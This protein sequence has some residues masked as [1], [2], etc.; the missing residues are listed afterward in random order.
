M[1]R[2]AITKPG[3][4]NR[5]N[6]PLL[7]AKNNTLS[8]VIFEASSQ[9]E[10]VTQ[11]VA[12]VVFLTSYPPRQCGIATFS[13]DLIKALNEKYGNSFKIS[14]YPLET[15]SDRH[16]YPDGISSSLNTDNA[17]DYIQ[18]VYTINA[19]PNIELVVIQ[20]EFGLF[21]GNEKGFLDFL[22]FLDKPVVITF[23]TVLP[24]PD[25]QM[26]QRVWRLGTRC[27][28]IIVM[29]QK[30]ADVLAHEYRIPESKITVIP[31]GTH[32]VH[33]ED[34]AVLKKKYKLSGKKVL[35]TFGLLGPGKSIET[36]LNALPEVVSKFP[37]TMFLIIGCTHP[38]L[39]QHEGEKYRD[40]LNE[41]VTTLGLA[42]N[43]RFVNEFLPLGDLL[44]Y[45]QLTDIYLFTSKDPNQA[46]SG[47]FSY[48]LSC[49][50][51]IISTPIP[52][53]LEVLKNGAG[54]VFD[55]EDSEQLKNALKELLASEAKR[56][57]MR[58]NGLLSSAASAWQ[59]AAISYGKVFEKVIGKEIRLTYQKP[60]IKL[61]H[62]KKLTT[63]VGIIQFAKINHPDLES[64]YTLDDN[65]RALIAL[66]K[67]YT[68][69]GEAS[70]LEYIKIYFNFVYSCFRHTARFL[71]YV[72]K[73]Y[74]FTEQNDE[75]NLEDACGRA[76][77]AV[78]YFLSIAGRLPEKY[79]PIREKARFLF[80][81]YF[82]G[83]HELESPRAIAFTIKGLYYYT[84]G[85][86]DVCVNAI[87]RKYADRLV[88]LYREVTSDNWQWF[89]GYL[90][91]GNS[92]LPQA[93]LMAYCMTLTSEYRCV[94]QESFDFLLSK[95][96]VNDKISVISNQKWLHRDIKSDG[97]YKGGEQPIDVAYTVLAL[98]FF[99]KVFPNNGYDKKMEQ[100]FNWFMGE[101][102]LGQ[103]MYNPCTCGCYDGLELNN[104]NLN[105][106]AESTV[107]YLLARMAFEE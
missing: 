44:E 25:N 78:G 21:S 92:V 9:A 71:N 5:L 96:F 107:S 48:A 24:N 52:H 45:L 65:A 12:E 32:L 75:V 89:E 46:V 7:L 15:D 90:T 100:A 18:A 4:K 105:Q 2:Q 53:A 33:Y 37:E 95:I 56:Q 34:K 83:C 3:L 39:V 67:H 13:N 104:V 103:T 10:H 80:E 70:D 16:I 22:D 85:I 97:I 11:D 68:L 19:N 64:G 87:L 29:T 47:T 31:H 14:V 38:T 55:F 54:I 23:H 77:W 27:D 79:R 49:G 66:C 76:I 51:P 91:Y 74:Q 69:T 30:S 59:N 99:H 36:T 6:I 98:R 61:D 81:E 63:E 35:S 26:I 40:F 72:N 84:Q 58:R 28:T 94:A 102:P 101:N 42:E 60:I 1:G 106:G 86:H 73:E 88:Q 41:K 8:N 43:V 57:N 50:C 62:L 93:M 17:F 20:H 82:K